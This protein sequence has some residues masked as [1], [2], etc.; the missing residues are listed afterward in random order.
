MIKDISGGKMQKKTTDI[1]L[2]GCPADCSDLRYATGLSSSD[3][4]VYCRKGGR[5]YLLVSPLDAGYVHRVV[6]NAQVFSFTDFHSRAGSGSQ[7]A[8]RILGLL[9]KI[10]AA[11]VAVPHY[12]PL[13]LA[14]KLE[15]LGLKIH[16]A[17]SPLFPE[18]AIKNSREIRMIT[19]AQAAAC[20]AMRAAWNM[21]AGAGITRR[22]KLKTG[23]QLLTASMVRERIDLVVRDFGCVCRK[24]IVACGAQAANPHEIGWGALRACR[25][26]VID[27]F[28]R[29][30]ASGYWGDLTRTVA[31]G[32]PPVNI[33]AMYA[34]VRAAH[35]KALARVK[36][37]AAAAE[38]HNAAVE[39]F[40]LR[41]FAGVEKEGQR[42]GFIHSVGHG[43]GLDIHESPPVGPGANKLA[44]GNII[45]V[46]PGLYY[47]GQAGIRIE[48]TVLV[49][50]GGF[51]L[52]AR[53]PYRFVL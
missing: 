42:D 16:V 15:A 33:C 50:R 53:F 35:A 47:R 51:R 43:V 8:E 40:K 12:F 17:E 20:H 2:A 34:A 36:G 28:P 7:A 27:I 26:I 38:V 29:H 6:R 3:P 32:R 18:R 44:P 22:G 21:I 30:V 13:G 19:Q 10:R 49:T 25:P 23:R 46:E 11:K 5:Q 1:L 41:G 45:T 24:T 39:V 31:R 9:K 14:R 52:L 4:V 37:G 48:D